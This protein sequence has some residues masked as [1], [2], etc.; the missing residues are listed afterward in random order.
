V[1]RSFAYYTGPAYGL[2]LDRWRPGWR[3]EVPRATSL[4]GLLIERLGVRPAAGSADGA[5]GRYDAGTV[6]AEERERSERRAARQRELTARLVTGPILRLPLASMQMGIDPGRVEPLD[7][8]GTV[9]GGM[10]LSDHWGVLD[11]RETETL[12]NTTFTEAAV[13]VDSDFDPA[14]PAGPGWTLALNSGWRVVADRGR[15]GWIVATGGR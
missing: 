10:R 15:G 12:I 11:A 4:S 8:Q 3:A 9:Y 13:G 6:R 1:V 5:A 2:L 7:A 14:A